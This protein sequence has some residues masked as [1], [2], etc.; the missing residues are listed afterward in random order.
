MRLS[1]MIVSF[2][3]S[4]QAW[5]ITAVLFYLFCLGLPLHE[6]YSNGIACLIAL[7]IVF[8]DERN[9]FK[10]EKAIL[11]SIACFVLVTG[12]TTATSID[13]AR[14]LTLNL[15]L[16]PAALVFYAIATQ[17]HLRNLDRL[18]L[19][20]TLMSLFISVEL[21]WHFWF[22]TSDD[23]IIWMSQASLTYLSIPN[24]LIL[25]A[26]ILPLSATITTTTGSAT[27]IALSATSLTL[28]LIVVIVFRSNA[29]LLVFILELLVVSMLF[30]RKHLLKALLLV[31]LLT[32]IG[33]A[34]QGFL[35]AN[36]FTDPVVW[37]NRL[38]LWWSGWLMFL[39]APLL[40][41]GPGSFAILG[42]RY[43]DQLSLPDWVKRDPRHTPW[44]HNLYLEMLSERGII[45]LISLIALLWVTFRKLVSLLQ[46][47]VHIYAVS[48]IASVLGLIVAGVFELSLLRH[49]V[50]VMLA[51]LMACTVA[52]SNTVE[53]EKRAG[54][55]TS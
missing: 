21:L 54:L 47:S 18:F 27:R 33:D 25:L 35:L 38:P 24:D 34:T 52:I 55:K 6:I 3:E 14:S 30:W 15:S 37:A 20:L 2:R 51:T 23:P 46:S 40:G 22:S 7:F 36:K 39:D 16:F 13:V 1:S 45:G 8:T 11:A 44:V 41:H 12:I 53:Q 31:T 4:K 42:E 26:L 28:F 9:P 17:F 50:L 43:I 29:A 5:I 32:A 19:V 49:W 48:I 10:N